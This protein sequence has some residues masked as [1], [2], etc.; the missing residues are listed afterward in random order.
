[1]MRIEV[2]LIIRDVCSRVRPPGTY[3]MSL[4]PGY[5]AMS[6][7]ELALLL[8]ISKAYTWDELC[9]ASECYIAYK[10]HSSSVDFE[11][12]CTQWFQAQGPDGYCCRNGWGFPLEYIKTT[13]ES[14]KILGAIQRETYP[15]RH[16]I[17]ECDIVWYYVQCINAIHIEKNNLIQQAKCVDMFASFTLED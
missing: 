16:V 15:R 13:S 6:T 12:F 14:I 7:H 11:Y 3:P 8:Q 2:G 17:M 9:I 1:M 4:P 10:L 5:Y